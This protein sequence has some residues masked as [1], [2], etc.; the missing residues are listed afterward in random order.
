MFRF[1]RI[2]MSAG[3]HGYKTQIKITPYGEK[4]YA[5]VLSV[6]FLFFKRKRL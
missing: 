5:T 4:N 6:V 1:S 3:V 2:K